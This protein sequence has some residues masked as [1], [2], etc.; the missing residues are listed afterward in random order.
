MKRTLILAIL[1]GLPLASTNLFADGASA[2]PSIEQ[3]WDIIQAQQEE[4][5]ALKQKQADTAAAATAADEKAEAAVVAVE[6]AGTQT[7]ST[8]S[9]A[10]R[11][12]VGG[13]GELHYNN[14]DADDSSKDE[15]EI[16]FHRFVLFFGHEF[17]DDLR[18]FSE[19]ELEHALSKDTD[20]GSNAGEVELEQAYI[21]YDINDQ[22]NTK[23]GLFILPVGIMNETHE[24]NTFYG[25]ERN[26]VENIIIPATWWAGGAAISG[27]HA[28]GVSW[29][30]AIHEGL[31]MPTSGSSAFRVRSGRQKTSEAVADKL[32]YTGRVK[33]TGIAGLEVGAAVNYQT[34]PSQA[35][36]DG[37]DDGIL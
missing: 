23:G 9:W 28:N 15:N 36:S 20:D 37:L 1:L 6:E 7:A 16:D 32:A 24:P 22:L 14:K 5:N 34:D 35:G 10:E 31:K 3:L 25:V 30:L 26:D 2:T 27:H 13:Y 4:I 11:T 21:E 33:Y 12:T 19:L 17:T 29:D 8:G 18:F